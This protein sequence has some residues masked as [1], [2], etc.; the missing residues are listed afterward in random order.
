MDRAQARLPNLS[1]DPK[2]IA[3]TSV[4][5]AVHVLVLMLLMLPTQTAPPKPL[6]D[7]PMIVVPEFHQVPPLIPILLTP[8]R[9]HSAAPQ[10]QAVPQ[11]TPVD[12]TRAPID[13][14]TLPALPDT[15]VIDSFEPAL[16]PAFAQISADVAPPPPYPIQALRR[17]LSGVVTLRVR[18]DVQGRPVDAVVDSSSGSKLLDEAALKFVLARWH[19]IPAMQGGGPIE[20]YALI[21]ISFVIER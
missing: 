16:P 6:V 13:Q 12:P 10:Q 21:P 5:I 4:A 8:P 18:V 14:F 7:N 20:A 9:P 1:L 19:F 2:R 17:R 11:V 3:G 15:D